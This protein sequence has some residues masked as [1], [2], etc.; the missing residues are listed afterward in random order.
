MR[1]LTTLLTALMLTVLAGF[2]M[3]RDIGPDEALRLRD[4]GTI[5]SFEKLNE[6]A[7]AKHPGGTI[8]ETE[9][10]N[11]YGKYVYQIELRDTQ[12]VQWDLKINAVTGQIYKNYQD[13]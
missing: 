6:Y 2:A 4:A 3:A 1:R 5:Q 8:T 7:L 12:G 11:E 13:K 9:L 10:E